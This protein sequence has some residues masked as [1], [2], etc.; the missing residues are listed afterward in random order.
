VYTFFFMYVCIFTYMCIYACVCI[1]THMC[2]QFSQ[3]RALEAVDLGVELQMFVPSYVCT[4]NWPHSCK[5]SWCSPSVL[6]PSELRIFFLGSNFRPVVSPEM[7]P[8]L[9]FPVYTVTG[10]FTP[11]IY[12]SLLT[13]IW[14]YLYH[15]YL[16]GCLIDICAKLSFVSFN[17]I[18]SFPLFYLTRK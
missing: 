6:P 7:P 8:T 5:N 13:F 1:Y 2:V 4:E 17:H 14:G 12:F 10:V 3:N 18:F 11:I 16:Y 9:I 15:L